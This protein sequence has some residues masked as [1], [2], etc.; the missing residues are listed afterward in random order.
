MNQ[1][2]ARIQA[3]AE[4]ATILM[5]T[6]SRELKAQGV[7]VIDLSLGEPDFLTPSH[8]CEAAKQAIDEGYH[9][10]P[11]V[12]GYPELRQ[13]IS[14]KFARDNNLHYSPDQI[15]VSTGAKQTLA[16]IMMSLLNPGDEVIVPIPYWVSYTAQIQLAEGKLVP[17]DTDIE[18]EFKITPTQLQNAITDKSK[19]FLFSTPCN[20]TGSAYTADELAALVEV[21]AAH[22]D[23]IIIS[24]E[25]YEYITFEGK[26]TS[27][28]SFDAVRDRTITVN[29][30]SKAFAMTGWRL[31]YMGAPTWIAKACTK[32]QGQFTSGANT[33]A[34]RAA[35]AALTT[36][37]APTMEMKEAFR[38][39]KDALIKRLEKV[40]GMQV[41]NP[42]GAFYLFPKV[43]DVFGK[44]HDGDFIANA[45][46]LS[47]QLLTK[48]HVSMV[49]GRAFGAPDYIRL[50]YANSMENLM[51]AADRIE[52]FFNKLV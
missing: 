23:L 35:L 40:P 29:G 45:D 11:P 31:G 5:A 49:T 18:H 4:S 41:N 20:P 36:D 38:Q 7:D 24:D 6:K 25:I 43:S 51:K 9:H 34:Q 44:S 14:D 33:I 17:I 39:R 12:P 32:M 3:L 10:Y 48:A 28:G 26:H 16:N 50:S 37:L 2:S 46:D 27:I 8:I 42:G 15:V 21:F 30:L 47:M 52:A 1:P 22:P 19:L 13:A